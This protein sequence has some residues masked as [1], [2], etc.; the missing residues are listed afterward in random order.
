MYA[1]FIG[2]DVSK[3]TL[4][5]VILTEQGH[6]CHT[7]QSTNNSQG[8]QQALESM[9][10]QAIALNTALFC[11]EHTGMYSYPL[12][13]LQQQGYALWLESGK[14]IKRSVVF[15]GAKTIKQMPNALPSM[16]AATMT[17]LDSGNHPIPS[18]NN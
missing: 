10:N 16:P 7:L 3:E 14:Q 12:T 2:V 4:D 5:W 13:R 9:Q 15:S 18:N 1:F 11:A 17:K 6:V 8:I